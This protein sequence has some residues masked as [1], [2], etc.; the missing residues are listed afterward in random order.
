MK[1]RNGFVSNSSSSSFVVGFKEIPKTIGQ[2][3]DLLF[4]S[5]EKCIS[6]YDTDAH[7]YEVAEQVF[8]DLEEA[9][10]LT[11]EEVIEEVCSGYFP[12]WPEEDWRHTPSAEFRRDFEKK[13]G[14]RVFDDEEAS[15]KWRNLRDKEWKAHEQAIKEA[16][17]EYV[18]ENWHLFEDCKCLRFS[19]AD[20]NGPFFALMEHGDIFHNLPH[21]RVSHH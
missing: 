2:T 1:I 18:E 14:K 16:A 8:E 5:G 4:P 15:E 13:T 20:D 17:T 21:I 7:V 19:Y 12:G 10:T 9:P 11:K 6:F 3:I